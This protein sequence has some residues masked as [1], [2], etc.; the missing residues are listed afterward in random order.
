[1]FSNFEKH[2]IED[3]FERNK[4]GKVNKIDLISKHG[5]SGKPF[6]AVYIHFDHWYDNINAKKFQEQVLNPDEKAQLIYD[7]HWFWIVL[8]NKG[9][10]IN[11]GDR[12]PRINLEGLTN[13]KSYCDVV[14]KVDSYLRIEKNEKN[15]TIEKTIEKTTA[16][17]GWKSLEEVDS[18]LS[19][20]KIENKCFTNSGK[21]LIEKWKNDE[22]PM[23]IF[24]LK[25]EIENLNEDDRNMAEIDLF[26]NESESEI[27]I[28]N[29][30]NELEAEYD[31]IEA[32]MTEDEEHFIQIDGRYVQSIEE[33]NKMLRE[34]LFKTQVQLQFQIQNAFNSELLKH[35]AF[36]E[37]I[38]L[39]QLHQA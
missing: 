25:K 7:K 26:I 6:W 21:I 10:K 30:I 1:V 13:T 22:N 9:C 39:R 36:T 2:D 38:A 33:E 37:I 29:A 14:K 31:E 16:D 8:E 35:Q 24:A 19:I 20:E 12:K 34:E 4:I 28:N 23:S 11:S 15:E 27:F 17:D 3:V 5:T 32:L 18:Y